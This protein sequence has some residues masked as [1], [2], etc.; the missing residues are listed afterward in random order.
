MLFARRS[1]LSVLRAPCSVLRRR[2]SPFERLHEAKQVARRPAPSR[3]ELARSTPKLHDARKT[4]HEEKGAQNG[5]LNM[6]YGP[7]TVVISA[8]GAER[9]EIGHPWIYRTDVV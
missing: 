5:R 9:I 2:R 8:R 4:L 6:S 7:P 1:A 3:D